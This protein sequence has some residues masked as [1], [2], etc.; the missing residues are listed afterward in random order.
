MEG[1]SGI[2]KTDMKIN[3]STDNHYLPN[4]STSTGNLQTDQNYKSDLMSSAFVKNNLTTYEKPSPSRKYLT[5]NEQTTLHMLFGSEKPD[6]L[7]FYGHD[8]VRNIHRG[9]LIDLL[10]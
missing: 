9:Q 3:L 5:S 10:A 7:T 4:P 1:L 8:K 2:E 6:E